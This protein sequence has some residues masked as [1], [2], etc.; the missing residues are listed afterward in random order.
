MRWHSSAAVPGSNRRAPTL[1][2]LL[3]ALVPASALADIHRCTDSEGLVT[4]TDSPS[5]KFKECTLLYRDTTA[6]RASP[7]AGTGGTPAPGAPRARTDSPAA[8]VR[9]N[10]GPENFP[11]IER[12][13]QRDRDLKARQIVERELVN[14]QRLLEEAR[15]QVAALGSVPADRADPRLRELQGAVSRHERNIAEIQR[16]LAV[17][18]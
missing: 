15:R 16:Q 1:F 10:P 13:E 6:P 5:R 7:G 18:K 3:L 2:I 17:M 9:A 14:E 12:G 8:A 4:F 11:R